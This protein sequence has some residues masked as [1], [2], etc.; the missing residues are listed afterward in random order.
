MSRDYRYVR[1]EFLNLPG[2]HSRA[3]ILALV[4]QGYVR[5]YDKRPMAGTVTLTMSDC[6]E[7]INLCLDAHREAENSI[8]KLTVLI[9]T[10]T[11]LRE[12]VQAEWDD[13]RQREAE[14]EEAKR[15]KQVEAEEQERESG[16]ALRELIGSRV[17][18]VRY[19]PQLQMSNGVSL[20][21]QFG[22]VPTTT[23]GITGSANFAV[24]QDLALADPA[25]DL[26]EFTD[27]YG[28][29]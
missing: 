18:V 22:G 7:E 12:A 20:L 6:S 25:D 29:D 28:S 9:D 16:S 15:A 13:F 27:T 21:Q 4:G 10:L 19:E 23:M 17:P 3:Y 11:G 14:F 24:A 5:D 2:F 1:R 8:H 26:E